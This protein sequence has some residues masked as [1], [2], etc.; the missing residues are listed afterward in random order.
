MAGCPDDRIP[1]CRGPRMSHDTV[2]MTDPL[3]MTRLPSDSSEMSSW[4]NRADEG[5]VD[6]CDRSTGVDR[7]GSGCRCSCSRP[8]SRFR[9][10][11]LTEPLMSTCSVASAPQMP[12]TVLFDP[13]FT[14]RRQGALCPVD[15]SPRR[16]CSSAPARRRDRVVGTVTTD[17]LPDAQDVA[18]LTGR[19]ER[20]FR[21][22]LPWPRSGCSEG[23]RRCQGPTNHHEL[24]T[25]E[26]R[27]E[28]ASKGSV[29]RSAARRA[30]ASS[31]TTTFSWTWRG[32]DP[33]T[34]SWRRLRHRYGYDKDD[35]ERQVDD[36]VLLKTGPLTRRLAAGP[37]ATRP[38]GGGSTPISVES[39]ASPS[40][41]RRLPAGEDHGRVAHHARLDRT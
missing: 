2:T 22:R 19:V 36:G 26:G 17:G 27:L 38:G 41:R 31:P 12:A 29:F 37:P 21:P 35:A 16:T 3:V 32:N 39:F 10:I 5:A 11:T 1:R 28:H 25:R 4:S 23:R 14:G 13:I 40:V 6:A 18:T 20:P 8:P 33:V 30:G 15:R 24:G 34:S 7:H 9:K